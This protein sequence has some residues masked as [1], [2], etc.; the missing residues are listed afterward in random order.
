MAEEVARKRK[1][2]VAA[3]PKELKEQLLNWK[4]VGGS[5]TLVDKRVFEKG[6][7]FEAPESAVRP[8]FRDLVELLTPPEKIVKV[9]PRE[10]KYFMREVVPTAEEQDDPDYEQLYEIIDA[11]DKVVSEKPLTKDIIADQ[12][13]ALNNPN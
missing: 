6:Q 4:V 12:L 7:T 10:P 11:N 1:N 13:K 2:A 3:E 5:I 8:A 9:V